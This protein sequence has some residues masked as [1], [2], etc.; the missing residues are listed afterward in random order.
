MLQD[1]LDRCFPD[2]AE[3]R[4]KK[5][6]SLVSELWRT[7]GERNPLHTDIEKVPVHPLFPIDKH[8][9][10]ANHIRGQMAISKVLVPTYKKEWGID[11]SLDHF[12][13]C[14][15]VH[16]AAKV[17]EFVEQDGKLVATPGFDH[18]LYAGRL[19]RDLG[20]PAEIAHMVAVHTYLGPLRLPRTGAA[21]LFQYLD[22]LCLPVFAEH[23]KSAVERHL[24][25]NK[26]SVAA[27]PDDVP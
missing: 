19:A 1:Q 18:A 17:V 7:V 23:G 4:D 13:A 11:L 9:S 20:F 14:A 10:L 5:L 8:G 27:P 6:R 21:Q 22:P 12:L 24:E 26:W 2:L 15:A 16:D 3:I 25:A